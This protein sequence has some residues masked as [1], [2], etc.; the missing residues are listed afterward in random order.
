MD[1]F[2]FPLEIKKS[3]MLYRTKAPPPSAARARL[4]PFF[5]AISLSALALGGVAALVHVRSAQP[6]REP[7]VPDADKDAARPALT[8]FQRLQQLPD[9][10]IRI[11]V[12]AL[13]G[14][15]V[16]WAARAMDG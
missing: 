10:Q 15:G 9:A 13:I 3:V 1:I 6:L 2:Y 12:L 16:L 7:P 8:W 11:G 5:L 14:V 4:S